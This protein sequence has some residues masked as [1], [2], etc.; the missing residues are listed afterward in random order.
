MR[1]GCWSAG[2]ALQAL[3]RHTLVLSKAMCALLAP[4][5]FLALLTVCNAQLVLTLMSNQ[6]IAPCASLAPSVIQWGLPSAL[7]VH[8]VLI[9]ELLELLPVLTHPRV[10]ALIATIGLP[11]K[12]LALLVDTVLISVSSFATFV[13][14]AI[15]GVFR[16]ARV[17]TPAKVERTAK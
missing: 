5:P 4:M 1:R 13:Q 14:L 7:T 15:S 10:I 11:I 2:H 6:G 8:R 12:V 3:L 17:A 9:K 16:A